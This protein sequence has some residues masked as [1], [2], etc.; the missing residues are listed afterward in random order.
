LKK[1][2]NEDI[3]QVKGLAESYVENGNY[4]RLKDYGEHPSLSAQ[5]VFSQYFAQLDR[6]IESASDRVRL[7]DDMLKLD[8]LNQPVWIQQYIET[9][10]YAKKHGDKKKTHKRAEEDYFCRGLESLADYILRADKEEQ[11]EFPILSSHALSVNPKR[12][13]FI[14]KDVEKEPGGVYMDSLGFTEE[15][16]QSNKVRSLSVR[17]NRE[18]RSVS[19]F[20]IYK[21]PELKEMQKGVN[22]LNNILG[23]S[24]KMSGIE[25][26]GKKE[27]YIWRANDTLKS[28]KE[29]AFA[30]WMKGEPRVQITGRSSNG[31]MIPDMRDML[32]I[33]VNSVRSPMTDINEL[34]SKW[35]G[36]MSFYG[37]AP[38]GE[39]MYA[40]ARKMRNEIQSD[41]SL[42][43]DKLRNPIQSRGY[44]KESTSYG[45]GV[46]SF[47][48]KE[49]VA[50][51]LT[52][53]KERAKG[54]EYYYPIYSLLKEKHKNNA[55]SSMYIML[56]LFDE[57]IELADLT[58]MERDAVYIIQQ[59]LAFENDIADPYER[60]R[61]YIGEKYEI[62]KSIKSIKYMLEQTISNKI[63]EAYLDGEENWESIYNHDEGTYQTC[64]QCKKEKL[65][66][67]RHYGKDNRK[68]NGYK[69][70]C[71]KCLK[72]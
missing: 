50:A 47:A 36:V 17:K 41:M 27:L 56:K 6:E 54:E 61:H 35:K 8:D 57:L 59:K 31:M 15:Q 14:T 40:K 37:V 1:V 29:M 66:N 21:Y 38:T 32:E 4:S 43:H 71:C 10:A 69:S 25:K 39:G 45:T 62:H 64:T 68:K 28:Q 55:G 22:I 5:E 33:L 53:Q 12:E 72:K 18:Y 34:E 60:V 9:E 67:E 49:H 42:V 52:V 65:L 51:L 24:N 63:V 13:V 58:S 11:W 44:K 23:M 2:K 16:Q 3:E 48:K 19:D 20:E 30:K 46:I 70:I 26:Q 7:V